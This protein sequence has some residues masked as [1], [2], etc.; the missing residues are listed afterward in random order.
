MF[1]SDLDGFAWGGTHYLIIDGQR[2]IYRMTWEPPWGYQNI[3]VMAHETGHGFGLPHSSGKYG[4]VYDN[5]WDVMSNSWLCR[6][7]DPVYGCVAQHTISPYKNLDGWFESGQIFTAPPQSQTTLNLERLALPQT[8]SYR[9][10]KIPIDGSTTHFYSVEARQRVT[11]SYDDQLPGS[12]VI[13]H[14]VNNNYAYVIDIDNN[15]NTG[16]AGA[17]WLIGESF[18]DASNRISVTVNSV[19]ASGFSVTISVDPPAEFVSCDQQ[20]QIP[21]LECDA[22]IALFNETNGPDWV[23]STGWLGKS[24][25]CTWKGVSCTSGHVTQLSL[26]NNQL[27]GSIPSELGDL[28]GL[29]SLD[30]SGNGLSGVIPAEIGNLSGLKHLVLENNS[31]S[32]A[33]PSSLSALTGLATL[34]L[35]WNMLTASEPGLMSFLIAKQPDWSQTQTVPP[36]D[37]QAV[38]QSTVVQL[39][40]TPIEYTANGGYYQVYYSPSESGPFSLHGVTSSKSASSYLAGNLASLSPYYFKLRT[41][42]PAHDGQP[43]SLWSEYTPVIT[44]TTTLAAPTLNLPENLSITD[45]PTPAFSWSTPPS[46]IQ[47]RLQVGMQA[48]FNNPIIDQTLSSTTFTAAEALESG[49]YYWR[50]QASDEKPTWS[51][52][53]AAWSLLIAPHQSFLPQLM[54]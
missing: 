21:E 13:I 51:D 18:V 33:I 39:T 41:Y 22:L 23:E 30:I 11:G 45:N 32:G 20:S 29:Q 24:D 37:L 50:V 10:V 15:G 53:S 1:N 14:E 5:A 54:R 26:A 38:G 2:K 42:T 27:S 40:W 35:G 36:L 34:E 4:N 47:Y 19:L 9:I 31:L 3:S 49:Q 17:M 16:D 6:I 25:P 48:D 12:A 43:N 28:S 44:S 46:A 8:G 52:W 7:R